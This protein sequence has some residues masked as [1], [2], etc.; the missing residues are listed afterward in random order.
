MGVG[1]DEAGRDEQ[2]IGVDLAGAAPGDLAD[3]GDPSVGDRDIGGELRL[4][5]TV[6]DRAATQDQINGHGPTPFRC[7]PDPYVTTV[8]KSA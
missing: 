6:D 7:L 5:R 4:A 1:V 8:G 2:A 3:L